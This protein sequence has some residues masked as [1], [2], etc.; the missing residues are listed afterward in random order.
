MELRE[1]EEWISKEENCKKQWK[2]EGEKRIG[3]K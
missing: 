2:I 3:I 1:K